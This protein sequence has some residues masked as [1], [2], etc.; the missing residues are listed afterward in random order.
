M[1][2]FLY[3]ELFNPPV[4]ILATGSKEGVDLGGSKCLLSINK[5]HD[6]F[7]EGNIVTEMSW[8]S[9]YDIEGLEDQIDTFTTKEFNSLRDDPKALVKTIIECLEKI[10]SEKKI[11]YGIADLEV[12]A[13]MN[14]NTV[15]P[16]LK[17]DPEL[18]NKLMDTH[19]KQRDENLFPTLIKGKE[20]QT[21][22]KI[23][24]QG[25]N[26]KNLHYYGLEF[27]E[28]AKKLLVGKGF[29]TG[30]VATSDKA[31]NFFMMN[32][33]IT[34]DQREPREFYIDQDC[35]TVIEA[36]IQRKVLFPISWFRIDIGI[37][38]L[39]TLELW[40]EI[41]KK[42][43]LQKILNKYTKYSLSIIKENQKK[44]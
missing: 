34:F 5:N 21:S 33:S 22:I 13:F 7:N 3:S 27:N 15:I 19:K 42:K 17:L 44:K 29:A 9:F 26:K 24:F 31:A 20:G 23:T 43:A 14:Q 32:D 1:G 2:S 41:Q 37:L 39:R 36:G 35:I 28:L 4:A 16:G 11:F 18:I 12:D 25:E 40:D 8:G 38:S 6:L 30:I 10:M